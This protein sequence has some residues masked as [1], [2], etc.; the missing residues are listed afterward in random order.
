M[1]KLRQGLLMP[2]GNIGY[3][4]VPKCASTSLKLALHEA[5]FKF[6]F[7]HRLCSV[8]RG[9][10]RDIHR[11]SNQKLRGDMFSAEHRIIVVR[12][13]VDR[14]ISAYANR[15]MDLS[16]LSQAKLDS[17]AVDKDF[18][19][20]PGLG[21]FLENLDNYL[22]VNSIEWHLRPLSAQLPRGL[23]SFNHIYSIS[24]IQDLE[25]DLGEIYNRAFSLPRKQTAGQSVS[26]K[27]LSSGQLEQIIEFC[28]EDYQLL[29]SWFK[30]DDVWSRWKSA[31]APQ[32]HHSAAR[33]FETTITMS[34]TP[35]KMLIAG[36]KGKKILFIDPETAHPESRFRLLLEDSL[37]KEGVLITTVVATGESPNGGVAGELI[38]AS[39]VEFQYPHS[40]TWWQELSCLRQ[41]F[42]QDKPDLIHCRGLRAAA[43]SL[44]ALI[45]L[46]SHA[47]L[48]LELLPR[49]VNE[50]RMRRS[51]IEKLRLRSV[52]LMNRVRSVGLLYW[53]A[54]EIQLQV[55]YN[56]RN[57]S[58]WTTLSGPVLNEE[59]FHLKT[60]D[61]DSHGVVLFNASSLRREEVVTATGLFL[62]LVERLQHNGS[63]KCIKLMMPSDLDVEHAF[64][65]VDVIQAL[66]GN[67]IEAVRGCLDPHTLAI[68]S[69]VVV[70]P[71]LASNTARCFA[72]C[73]MHAGRPLVVPDDDWG[74]HFVKQGN[75]GYLFCEDCVD[76]GV[77]GIEKLITTNGL[78]EKMGFKA[79]L[80][81]E[82]RFTHAAATETAYAHFST[83]LSS[84]GRRSLF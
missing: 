56:H 64:L 71:S 12:D 40:L 57:R 15:V 33:R 10:R 79:R 45:G 30:L 77:Q 43:I 51:I 65:Q 58:Q 16:A 34:R 66:E 4:D 32:K 3:F 55:F 61:L 38:Q 37:S 68:T 42:V 39:D 74:R 73:A 35:S 69:Q 62:N 72:V 48:S 54:S 14:F 9:G 75:S 22:Q 6:P 82:I 49:P 31:Q 81:T 26:I 59:L 29:D 60:I 76:E 21:Q 24:R 53:L 17:A 78:P 1:P 46:E 52:R 47:V 19:F 20:N 36:L 83:L 13:P 50:S 70:I 44:L 63:L 7:E 25:S 23:D 84:E 80:T 8:N 28:R 5:E 2:S 67:K 18:I 11:F 27:Q 41:V